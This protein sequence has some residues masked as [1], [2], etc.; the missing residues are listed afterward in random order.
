MKS[1]LNSVSK[2]FKQSFFIISVAIFIMFWLD[3]YIKSHDNLSSIITWIG[4]IFTVVG[5]IVGLYVVYKS[6]EA[7]LK[8]IDSDTKISY[9]EL[10]TKLI[11]FRMNIVVRLNF[12]RSRLGNNID[13]IEEEI[14][15][16]KIK[17]MLN[18]ISKELHGLEP[19]IRINFSEETVNKFIECREFA[20]KCN[21]LRQMKKFQDSVNYHN[22]MRVSFQELMNIYIPND[23]KFIKV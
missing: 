14:E 12:V 3:V 22:M 11:D 23:M 18:P 20:F 10:N 1:V 13:N 16:D 19:L 17:N 8:K 2:H 21:E 5:T 15:I 4:L 9:N 6:H 7:T